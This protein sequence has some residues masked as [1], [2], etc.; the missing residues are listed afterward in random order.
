MLQAR[1]KES[2][3]I[4]LPSTLILC[5]AGSSLSFCSN[6]ASCLTNR[7]HF[8]WDTVGEIYFVSGKD[9]LTQ[10]FSIVPNILPVDV[11]AFS[12]RI[13]SDCGQLHRRLEEE[14]MDARMPCKQP[15]RMDAR[16]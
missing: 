1:L 16:R 9:I 3:L 6:H 2:L 4:R 13:R 15:S 10:I 11:F 7:C 5:I 14:R 8:S 12:S